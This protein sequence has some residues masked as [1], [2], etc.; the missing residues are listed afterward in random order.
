[1]ETARPAL[2]ALREASERARSIASALE[3]LALIR[4]QERAMPFLRSH[5]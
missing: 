5:R 1:V 3:V 2:E 4:E